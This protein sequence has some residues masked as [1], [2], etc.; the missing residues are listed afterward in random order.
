[1]RLKRLDRSVRVIPIEGSGD[2]AI[3]SVSEPV[4]AFCEGFCSFCYVAA[5]HCRPQVC[6]V[7]PVHRYAR[8]PGFYCPD[9]NSFMVL[10]HHPIVVS[11]QELQ[12]AR[13]VS[14]ERILC[15]DGLRFDHT[16][17]EALATI[18]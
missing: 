17:C 6:I 10:M 7:T 16:S 1:M 5:G 18:M 12:H 4:G 13:H 2:S 3:K 14:V 15:V 8:S 9:V 11:H